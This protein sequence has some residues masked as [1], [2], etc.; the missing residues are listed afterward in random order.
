MSASNNIAFIL[1]DLVVFDSHIKP[2]IDYSRDGNYNFY[3]YH[4]N[5][6]Y[7]SKKIIKNNNSTT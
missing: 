3:V 6:F 1:K 2:L 5:N 4:V 7:P